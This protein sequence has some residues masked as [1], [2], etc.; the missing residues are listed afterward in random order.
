M[1]KFKPGDRVRRITCDGFHHGNRMVRIGDERTVSYITD[2]NSII[3][4]EHEGS[5]DPEYFE[6]IE[7]KPVRQNPFIKITPP[8]PEKREIS[9]SVSFVYNSNGYSL[10]QA[11]PTNNKELIAF[12]GYDHNTALFDQK[13]LREIGQKFIDLADALKEINS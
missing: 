1:N 2:Y 3:L 10:L 9:F 12:E 7:E 4:Q 8:Q 11:K 5:F 13:Q 6:M